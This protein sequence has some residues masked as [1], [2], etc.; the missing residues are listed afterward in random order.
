MLTHK[1]TQTIKTPRLTLRR[2]TI[3]D[4]RAM[5]D[6]WAGDEA[7]TK[8]LTWPPHG[9]PE[10][11]QLILEDWVD[12]YEKP[13]FYQWAI[14]P[15]EL[16]QPIGSISGVEIDERIERAHIGYCIG[17]QWWNKGYT[18][19]ALAA[20]IDFFFREVNARRVDARHDSR[21]G[22]SGAVMRKCGMKHE[23]TLRGSGWSNSGWGDMEWYGILRDEWEGKL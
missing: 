21:N 8:F 19:E 12:G 9:C 13:D 10:I 4:A 20:V 23:G 16:G 22:A 1:G 3:D 5:Y 15:N 18:S 11:S 7:V 14:V 6:N 17:R 2:F